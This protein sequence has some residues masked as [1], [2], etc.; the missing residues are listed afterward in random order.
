[1]SFRIIKKIYFNLCFF[2]KKHIFKY[3]I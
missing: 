3:F 2:N 1:M